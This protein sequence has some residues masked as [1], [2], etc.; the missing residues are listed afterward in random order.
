VYFLLTIGLE[1]VPLHTLKF[2][3]IRTWWDHLIFGQRDTPQSYFQPLLGSSDDA[4]NAITNEDADVIAERHRVIGDYPENVIIYLHNLRKVL[5][6]L[7]NS[8]LQLISLA[9][10]HSSGMLNE[11]F[12]LIM[13]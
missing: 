9:F 6:D 4:S 3:R 8:S 10:S 5:I 1:F 11:Y 13:P 12:M 7:F 2:S